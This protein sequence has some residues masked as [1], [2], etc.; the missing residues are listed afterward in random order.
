MINVIAFLI[1]FIFVYSISVYAVGDPLAMPNNKFGIGI[2]SPES[3]IPEAAS[4]VDANGDWGYVVIVI[5]KSERNVDRWQNVFHLLSKNH[6]IPI[7]RIATDLDSKGYWQRPT[8]EDAHSWADFL[9]K[10][11]WPTKDHFVQVYNEVNNA[12]EWGG[13][14]DA[15]SYTKELG[16]TIDALRTKGLDFFVLGSPMDLSLETTSTS[17]SPSTFFQTMSSVDPDIFKKLDGWASHS[18]PNP[19]FS[20]SP[21]AGGRTSVS[22]FSW[23]LAQVALYL[24]GKKLP[25][26]ITETGWQRK[27]TGTSGVDET[28]IA[29][30]Y[31]T[32]FN[33]VWND[34]RVAAV[35]PFVFDY[36][37]GQF[38]QFSFKTKDEKV[39]GRKYYSYFDT[40]RDLLKVKGEP[41]REDLTGDIKV[42]IA[43]VII[44]D[45]NSD[46]NL[47][48]KNTGN[49]IWNITDG[50]K[51]DLVGPDLKTNDVKFSKS[52]IYP[53]EDATVNFKISSIREGI[54]PL[55]IKV[56]DG[57]KVLGEKTIN[58]E[59]R[60]Y[61]SLILEA[62]ARS[63]PHL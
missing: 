41:E 18:Y 8:D 21:L 28:Q 30:Y 52:E 20:A 53:G 23:E 46:V 24:D 11:Y 61:L 42:D 36:P 19:G 22:G 49:Y 10:L 39:L 26:F 1:L 12:N 13:Q 55:D 3:D 50:F 63:L 33:Q 32:A 43:K 40:I 59:S 62:I 58:V 45:R 37:D 31:K 48:V 6:L 44:P 5:K 56:A 35:A 15:A 51:I 54:L 34:Q 29:A 25:V 17:L 60:S 7:V 27:D 47:K 57:D 2:L 9:S 38:N 16:K 14:V 4:L